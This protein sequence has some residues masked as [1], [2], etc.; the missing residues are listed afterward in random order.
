MTD[1][2]MIYSTPEPDGPSLLSKQLT[3]RH[4][5]KPPPFNLKNDG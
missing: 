2:V 1:C 4:E 5:H 3:T